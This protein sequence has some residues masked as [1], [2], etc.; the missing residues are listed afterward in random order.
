MG[1]KAHP[2]KTLFFLF[3]FF[4]DRLAETRAAFA[5]MYEPGIKKKDKRLECG[6]YKFIYYIPGILR[7]N[8]S[9]VKDFLL[10]TFDTYSSN[11][12]LLIR[13]L[14]LV[15]TYMTRIYQYTLVSNTY[16]YT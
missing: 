11:F 13:N 4:R 3:F 10:S 7:I 1:N 6:I 9:L 2:E 12:L 5:I 8:S 14:L 15:D 16:I